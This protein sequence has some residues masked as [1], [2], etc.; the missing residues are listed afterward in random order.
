MSFALWP[1]DVRFPVMARRTMT[2]EGTK[3]TLIAG[4]DQTALLDIGRTTTGIDFA[5]GV[6]LRRS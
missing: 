4:S 5:D 6:L 3:I 1:I 2:V